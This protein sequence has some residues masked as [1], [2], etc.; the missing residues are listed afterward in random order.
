MGSSIPPTVKTIG[1][2]INGQS[3]SVPANQNVVQLLEYLDIPSRAIAV[4]INRELV[5]GGDF[6]HK[7]IHPD[8]QIEIV[9]LV[10]GG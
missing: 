4:E 1:V 8:D 10:G 5:T 7:T 9:T 2:V 3:Q 6:E